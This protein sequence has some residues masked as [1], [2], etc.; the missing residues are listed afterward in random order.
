MKPTLQEA[1]EVIVDCLNHR[2]D[3][4]EKRI[5]FFKHPRR[6]KYNLLVIQADEE[7]LEQVRAVRKEILD[8]YPDRTSAPA[9][10]CRH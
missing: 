9:S 2:I 3:Q 4:L 5:D 8:G 7:E 10:D 1:V 6:R